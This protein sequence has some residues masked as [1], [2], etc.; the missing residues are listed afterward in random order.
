MYNEHCRCNSSCG[1]PGKKLSSLNG[2]ISRFNFYPHPNQQPKLPHR[3]P[4]GSAW[5]LNAYPS[6]K[7]ISSAPIPYPW[8]N[9]S[10]SLW[11]LKTFPPVLFGAVAA[12]KLARKKYCTLAHFT[13]GIFAC[14]AASW[15][16]W[17]IG[18]E[19]KS[20]EISWRNDSTA[21]PSREENQK[22]RALHSQCI[23]VQVIWQEILEA[24]VKFQT[25][26][27]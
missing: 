21:A 5:K 4:T 17:G 11:H 16:H 24:F 1:S 12:V 19:A 13:F 18:I 6:F 2:F 7:A 22:L 25:G 26:F 20:A 23:V 15:C 9:V 8:P 14:S 3:V 27:Q 10:V